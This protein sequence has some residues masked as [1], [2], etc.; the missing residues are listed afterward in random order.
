MTFRLMAIGFVALLAGSAGA[1]AEVLSIP[2]NKSH[3]LRLDRPAAVVLLANP[4]LADIIVETPTLIFLQGRAP[5]ETNLVILDDRQGEI[6][7]Y[8]LVVSP[9]TARHVTV[10]RNVGARQSLTCLTNCTPEQAN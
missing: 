10:H 1:A 4:E 9:V 5:G 2:L 6:A 3:V 8:E 7:T